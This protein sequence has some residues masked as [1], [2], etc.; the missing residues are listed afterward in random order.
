MRATIWQ[1]CL[2]STALTPPGVYVTLLAV[3]GLGLGATPA[4]ACTIDSSTNYVCEG[5]QTESRVIEEDNVSVTTEPGFSID[6]PAG[7]GLAITGAGAHSFIDT[8][9]ASL[10]TAGTAGLT[11]TS[12]GDAGD[13][14]G[15]ITIS[16][17]DDITGFDGIEAKNSG[18][19][20]I[21][22]TANGTVTGNGIFGI[23]AHNANGT[24]LTI[25]TGGDSAIR[26]EVDGIQGRNLG[27]GAVNVSIG[28]TLT[29]TTY[30]AI[31]VQNEASGTDL[32]LTTETG[33]FLTAG[34]D[35]IDAV[36]RGTGD[37][38]LAILGGI[39]AQQHAVLVTGDG[40]S[41]SVATGADSTITGTT[42]NGIDALASG[43]ST[44]EIDA[45]GTISGD[46][47]G[48]R[49]RNTGTGSTAV[50]ISGTVTSGTYDGL[51]IEHAV[52]EALARAQ[53]G[54]VTV[55]VL[56]GAMVTGADDGIQ[57]FNH[58][59]SDT[60]ITIDGTVQGIADAGVFTS[61]EGGDQSVIVGQNGEV[62]GRLYGIWLDD[63]GA[64]MIEQ[65]GVVEGGRHGVWFDNPGSIVNRG[66]VMGTD[67]VDVDLDLGGITVT[68]G[69]IAGEGV[70][71]V[72]SGRIVGGITDGGPQIAIGLNQDN[73]RLELQ[74]GSEI[75]GLVFMTD[76]SAVNN[77]FALGGDE[78]ASFDAT[79]LGS[80]Y[81]G[82]TGYEKT[83]ES[84]WT[85][86][87]A[88]STST[89]WSVFGGS[90]A[91]SDDA[92]LGDASGTLTLDGGALRV[93]GTD[94]AETAR[95]VVLGDAGGNLEIVEAGHSL[96]IGQ[97]I[98]G[99]GNLLKSGAGHLIFSGSNSHTGAITVDSG[100]LQV[101]GS[102]ADA[103]LLTVN[104][105][106][107]LGGSGVVGD[108]TVADGGVLAPGGSIGTLRVEGDLVLEQGS[109]LDFEFG[110]P[111]AT[112]GGGTSDRIDVAGDLSLNARLDMSQSG[113]SADGTAGLGYYRL[114]TYGGSLMGDG[115]TIG[116]TGAFP[117]I[118][119]FEIQAGE[120]RIDLLVGAV[121][122]DDLQHWQGGD[123]V[124]DGTNPQ[125]RNQGGDHPSSWAG[126][127]AAFK[128]EPGSFDGGTIA[129]EGTQSFKGLQ[130]VDEGYRLEGDGVLEVDGSERADGNAEIR[131]LADS[132]VIATEIGGAGGITKTQGGTLVLEGVNTYAGGTRFL[133]GAIEVSA[134][135]S[136]GASSGAL[137][138]E[139]GS[140]RVAGNDYA[141]TARDIAWGENGGSF[142]I[143]A[144]DHEFTVA[145]SLAGEG[146]LFKQGE[147]TLV[148]TGENAYGNTLVEAG[149]LVGNAASLSG[150]IANAGTL[151]FDQMDDE[152]FSGLIAGYGGSSG[153]VVKRGA[154]ILTLGGA[155][156]LD[157][158]VASGGIV[159]DAARFGGDVLL[160]GSATS[161]TF[162][163][164]GNAGYGGEI[165]GNG[166]LTLEGPG[167]VLLTGDS[168]GFGGHTTVSGGS[169]FVGNAD[170]EGA[171]GGSVDVWSGATLG[172]S[173]TIGSGT[174]ST[175]TLGED[176]TFAPGSSIGTLIVDGDLVFDAGSRFAV[177]V[178]PGGTG[179]DLVSVTGVAT[180][181]GGTV[182]HIGMTGTYDPTSTY[183]IL[184]AD[185]GVDGTFDGVSSDF[186][187]LD[188]SLSY[189]ANDV[190]LSLVRN[191]VDFADAGE[192][193]NQI[194]TAEGLES[195]GFGDDLY[196]A[197]VQLDAPTALEAFDQ[198]SGEIHASAVTGLIEDSR[199][200][201][202][203]AN[204]R[205]R[206][207]FTG[208][209]HRCRRC[210]PMAR[211]AHRSLLPRPISALR[212]GPARSA[213]GTAQRAT[214]MPPRST[215][216][217]AGCWWVPMRRWAGTGGSGSW[218]DIAVR[219][220]M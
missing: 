205:L 88:T 69:A 175:V 47:N 75:E 28:G 107:T 151:V 191:N 121:G 174:G 59:P 80:Q 85:L 120:G 219:A 137:E 215:G 76:G 67:G 35:G 14:A 180:L 71:I 153:A 1:A 7:P 53:S 200:I 65:G 41:L 187:F 217:Q 3:A 51:G 9:A 117:G 17:N 77:V 158:T 89:P 128:N 19:G 25:V 50:T 31:D 96:S 162:N 74:R 199:H 212:P 6:A 122:D 113:D 16:T 29:G 194:A 94:F 161:L 188:P 111:S 104:S 116:D 20:A 64:V 135:A 103:S 125:W 21:S 63:P 181:D 164:A 204:D 202:S 22:V 2:S 141:S 39:L 155:S 106:A 213:R 145:Q 172:G 134:E 143:V 184:S 33:S 150:D 54:D 211:M 97:G 37:T 114:M 206:A 58:G 101:D 146:S 57:V 163:G 198:L 84:E 176:S 62:M 93:T 208:S 118:N 40:Q 126:N 177:E 98:A 173:G 220:A 90:L 130:F 109:V 79:A 167:R 185:E 129:V 157:W 159:T 127:T 166:A 44:L 95:A 169:L 196:D 32:T 38:T 190:L 73:N 147:G 193:P 15:S 170:G 210:S 139:G 18:G 160:D 45:A 92:Q 78:N 11:I 132:A 34:D 4:L 105:G 186:A 119:G 27:T 23:E 13:T 100:T 203:A 183:T 131:V 46:I 218:P 110:A 99:S 26:G 171:L 144:A 86:T 10:S 189:T 48:I 142:D 140:L 56:S 133:D 52:T 87:G 81:A 152:S 91:I 124:W 148:L 83:G 102:A 8:N 24:D 156:T 49:A 136:L 112:A 30:D 43:S 207:A 192:T 195:L 72:N 214:A 179:S 182:A 82:F 168:S 115:L 149:T 5:T 36:N 61:S 60:T 66:T 12:T 216:A 70:S 108:T 178:S 55:E 197:I 68:T 165:S 209:G 42:G 123:G 138:F 201:R 154:G